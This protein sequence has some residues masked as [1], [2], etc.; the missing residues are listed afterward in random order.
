MANGFSGSG[1][2]PEPDGPSEDPPDRLM[3]PFGYPSVIMMAPFS[4]R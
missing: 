2:P 1:C 4:L 3:L